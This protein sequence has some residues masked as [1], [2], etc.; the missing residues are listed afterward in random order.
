MEEAAANAAA[1]SQ[2]MGE[3]QGDAEGADDDTPDE[4]ERA[5]LG[6]DAAAA[7][8][9]AKKTQDREAFDRQLKEL[10]R[11][12]ALEEEN[13][14][15]KK[16][17]HCSLLVSSLGHFIFLTYNLHDSVSLKI[18]WHQSSAED[19]LRRPLDPLRVP[20]YIFNLETA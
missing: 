14:A 19:F 3:S 12:K 2:I 6:S 8:S 20:K 11:L 9:R 13:A 18:P 1:E 15:L 16:V 4:E 7:R 5:D 10:E 17:T